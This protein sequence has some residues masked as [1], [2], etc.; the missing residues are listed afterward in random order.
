MRARAGDRVV[1]HSRTVGG[2]EKVAEIV[3]VMGPNG[4]PPYRVRS[5]DGHETV[6]A[7]GPDSV[8]EHR[9]DRDR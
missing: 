3:E 9:A 5:R 8:V 4:E 6:V 2:H 7:P 1:T